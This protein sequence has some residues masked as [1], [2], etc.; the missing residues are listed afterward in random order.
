M[1]S[2]QA[3]RE[4]MLVPLAG[5]WSTDERLNFK[6]LKCFKEFTEILLK[7]V[8]TAFPNIILPHMDDDSICSLVLHHNVPKFL[9]H[10]R[11]GCLRKAAGSCSPPTDVS[12]NRVAHY[13]L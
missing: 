7:A 6:S 12:D 3:N 9:V 10:I 1:Y 2:A 4:N 11:D 8:L 5:E 13:S